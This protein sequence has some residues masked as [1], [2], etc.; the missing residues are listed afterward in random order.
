MKP[1]CRCKDCKLNNGY[2]M[3]GNAEEGLHFYKVQR[4]YVEASDDVFLDRSLCLFQVSLANHSWVSFVGFAESYTEVVRNMPS[5]F[6]RLPAELQQVVTK[7]SGCEKFVSIDGIWKL[8]HPHCLYPVKAE[9]AGL[10]TINYPNVCTEEPETQASAFC[11]EHSELAMGKNIPTNLREFIHD[12]CKVPR[13]HDGS[14]PSEVNVKNAEKIND[15]VANLQTDSKHRGLSAAQSQGTEMFIS[16]YHSILQEC[17]SDENGDAVC[18]KDTGES[19]KPQRKW[20]RGLLHFVRGGGHIERWCPLYVSEGP[21]QVFLITLQYLLKRLEGIPESQWEDVVVSYDNMCNLDKLRVAK[22]QLPLPEPYNLM[23]LKVR[24][25]VDRLHM[26]NHIDPRC[27]ITYGSDDLKEKY[28]HLNTP[29]A[30]QTF[31]WAGRFKKIM[32]AM[33]K[34]RF[35]FFYH[36]MVSRRNRYIAVCYQENRVPEFPSA[37]GKSKVQ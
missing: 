25:I 32:C 12:Y 30:E 3:F 26:R 34:R 9:V 7:E 19:Q 10:P 1:S 22:K 33:P 2:S 17:E 15:V 11:T 36:R 21:G 23:W 16:K 27:K 18:N 28:P 13:N 14:D 31:I 37:H 24:K 5:G 35:L 8:R 29:V 4:P 6:Q 20:S